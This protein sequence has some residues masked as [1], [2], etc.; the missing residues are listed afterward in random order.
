M[1]LDHAFG[2]SAPWTVGVEE[3]LQIVDGESL[4]LVPRIED[5][6][7]EIP[8]GEAAHI[9]RELL[10]SVLEI[11][12]PICADVTE[13]RTELAKRR[14]LVADLAARHGLLIA[15]AGTHPFS[16]WDSQR[17]TEQDR[18]L[19]IVD[20]LQWVARRELIFGLH[21][22]VGVDSPDKAIAI[23]NGIRTWLPHLLALSTNS[24][25]WHGHATG[26]KSSRVP[27]F[28]AFPRAGLPP[29]FADWDAFSEHVDRGVRMGAIGDYTYIWWDVRPH[30]RFGT[31]EIRIC[32]AQTRLEDTMAIVAL[33]QAT[34]AWLGDLHD[35][36][37][38]PPVRPLEL[39]GEN[40]WRAVRFGLDTDMIRFED[41]TQQ[42]CRAEL[43][44]LIAAVRP[45]AERLGSVHEIERVESILGELQ[46]GADRQLSMFE[47]T[48]SLVEVT[49]SLTQ[50]TLAAAAP[51]VPDGE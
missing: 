5:L 26:L 47:R 20:A 29:A 24:P 28:K 10:Q 31:V 14:Q 43:G 23:H 37:E 3:E 46:T 36:G 11:S 12:T 2:S 41:E 49:R 51:R 32:D 34:A 25:F 4:D 40:K 8:E 13:A 6:L 48:G 9:K 33:V 16:R 38:D 45:Y 21:V 17:V 19:Q 30:P 7:T 42:P 35:A 1:S 44:R 39:I 18:Y 22:H 50:A 27:I 15:S